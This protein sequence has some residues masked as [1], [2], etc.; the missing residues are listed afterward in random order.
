MWK[1]IRENWLY[2]MWGLLIGY[3]I[4]KGM[5]WMAW[6]CVLGA[7]VMYWAIRVEREGRK[8]EGGEENRDSMSLLE[9][10]RRQSEQARELY[11]MVEHSLADIR[12]K[13]EGEKIEYGSDPEVRT[14]IVR[15]VGG[16]VNH[17]SVPKGV[18]VKI[19]YEDVAGDRVVSF[20]SS[21]WW[22]EAGIFEPEQ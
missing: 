13:R 12:S 11:R 9:E 1:W 16:L 17:V 3:S 2:G 22:D 21:G 10:C 5:Q 4:V 15:I 6:Y 7:W 18:E 8:V 20:S 14:V 19:V